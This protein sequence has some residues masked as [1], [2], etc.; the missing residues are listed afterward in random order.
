MRKRETERERAMDGYEKSDDRKEGRK[1][2]K[3]ERRKEGRKEENKEESSIVRW[4]VRKEK[5]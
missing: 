2:R 3:K 5:R 1:E 4:E